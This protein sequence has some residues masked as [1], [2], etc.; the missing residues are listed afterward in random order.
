[1]TR[2]IADLVRGHPPTSL[3]VF[4]DGAVP[5]QAARVARYRRGLHAARRDV[6]WRDVSGFPDALTLF[7]VGRAAVRQGL[8]VVDRRGRLRLGLDAR[9]ALWRELPRYRWRSRLFD[10]LGISARLEK[11]VTPRAARRTAS[12]QPV[13]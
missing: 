8:A 9:V 7:G 13:S 5:R 10:C 12:A 2:V 11:P 1:M 4:Y 6:L 3:T